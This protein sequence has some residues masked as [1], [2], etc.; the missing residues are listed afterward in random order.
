MYYLL[1]WGKFYV[2][3]YLAEYIINSNREQYSKKWQCRAGQDR[4]IYG[5][6]V[7]IIISIWK[8]VFQSHQIQG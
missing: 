8:T 4:D 3:I 2:F 5:Q 6:N 7:G 1:P